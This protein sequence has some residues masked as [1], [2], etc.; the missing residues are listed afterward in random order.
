[1]TTSRRSP[2]NVLP[3]SAR[4]LGRWGWV[5][6]EVALGA[7]LAVVAGF[8]AV[9]IAQSW[10]GAYWVVDAGAGA[11]VGGFAVGRRV[12]RGW[13]AAGGLVVAGAA[14]VV[15]GVGGLPSE[16]GPAV[17]LGLSVLVG[18]AIRVLPSRAACRVAAGGLVVAAAS[19]PWAHNGAVVTL[20][21]GGWL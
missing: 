19:V 12:D 20:N 21:V 6:G 3:E 4:R 11:L 2:A 5:A 1:M 16:P 7:G 10:G 15:A 18:S 14:V 9:R 17:A 13:A 8:W